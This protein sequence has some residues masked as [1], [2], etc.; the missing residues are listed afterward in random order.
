[1]MTLLPGH[2]S[3]GGV[4]NMVFTLAEALTM[5][6]LKNSRVIAGNKGLDREIRFVNVMEVPDIID[7]VSEKELLLTTGYPFKD[8]SKNFIELIKKLSNK[9]LTGLAIKTQRFSI[10]FLKKR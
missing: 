6:C 1:M 8:S 7:W 9:K 4:N 3:G 5:D 2:Y 10:A